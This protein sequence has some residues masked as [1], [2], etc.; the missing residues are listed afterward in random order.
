[1][2]EGQIA[3]EIVTP[4]GRAL[5]ASA[6]EIAVPSVNGEFGVVPGH[7]PL[8]AAVRTGLLSYRV[9]AETRRVA[10]GSGFAD[11]GPDRLTV[12]TDLCVERGEIDP[13]EVR[14]D[15]AE[16]QAAIA[17]RE[18][19]TEKTGLADASRVLYQRDNEIRLNLGA[20]AIEDA[21]LRFLIARELWLA[22]QLE[23][24]GDPPAA[25]MRPYEEWG[26]P[27]PT[28]DDEAPAKAEH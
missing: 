6:D 16:V 7:F 12:L 23:L 4:K 17:K 14:K 2:S 13:V 10:I 28:P 3:L 5:A 24:Y 9:G 15:L 26:P 8:L 18:A 22:A 27:S 20:E 21:E 1:M 11:V 19:H 25:T